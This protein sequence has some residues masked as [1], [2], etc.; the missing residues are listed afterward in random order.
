MAGL[1]GIK[2]KRSVGR[3]RQ[4]LDAARRAGR[5]PKPICWLP[6]A[7][8]SGQAGEGSTSS[9]L[10]ATDVPQ[11]Q[12]ECGAEWEG[13]TPTSHAQSGTDVLRL[14]ILSYGK[15]D[16]HIRG[17]LFTSGMWAILTGG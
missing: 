9:C 13:F 17:A 7:L 5:N 15:E 8:G 1:D 12:L 14:L 2:N 6:A 16:V 11:G 3:V 4:D 10:L